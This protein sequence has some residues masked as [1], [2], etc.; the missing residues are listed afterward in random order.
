MRI[1]S[2]KFRGKS[3]I[4]SDHF[5]SLRPTTDK[6]REA[7]F[8]ILSFGKF[9][10]EI[11]F[12]LVGANVLDVCCG[13]GAVG[14]EAL[15]RGANSVTFIE[16]NRDHL[17]LVEKN[18]ELLGVKNDVKIL[19]FDAKKLPRN[20]KIFDLVFLDP[21]YEEDYSAIIS[22]LI[23]QNWISQK[24]LFVAEFQSGKSPLSFLLENFILLD[25]RNYGRGSFVFFRVCPES[26]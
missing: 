4:K 8:N 14:F 22:S 10:H 16:K 9:I 1:V 26:F 7:L 17:E 2:G 6:A 25:E 24:T 23:G 18:S 13:T 11:N 5:K 20:E 15:S 21:P 12:N 19:C 3:L